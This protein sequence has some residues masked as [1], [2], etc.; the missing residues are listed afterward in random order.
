[1]KSAFEARSLQRLFQLQGSEYDGES[2]QAQVAIASNQQPSFSPGRPDSNH[3][4]PILFT[5]MSPSEPQRLPGY[6]ADTP[7]AP[8]KP[9]SSAGSGFSLFA[10]LVL[11]T[12]IGLFLGIYEWN[13]FLALASTLMVAPALIRTTVL[14]D[15]QRRLGKP[16][17]LVE[18][19]R[20]FAGSLLMVLLTGLAGLLAFVLVSLIFGLI[21]LLFGWAMGIEGLEFESAV[22]GTAGGIV[23]GMGGALLTVTYVAWRY[24]FPEEETPAQRAAREAR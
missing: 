14:A 19:F 9:E 13:R 10:L 7:E 3:P 20:S 5:N 12:C 4:H 22:V 8:R 18:R 17:T 2:A 23:W 24:W 21:G 15:R 1:M 6:A 11:L 16:W